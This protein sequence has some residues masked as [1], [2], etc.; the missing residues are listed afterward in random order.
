MG[1]PAY[2]TVEQ[3]SA[4][5]DFKA[6]AFEASRLNRLVLSASRRID[7]M[8]HRHFYPLTETRSYHLGGGGGF[9]LGADLFALTAVT[10]D[11][12][13]ITISTVTLS[14]GTPPYHWISQTGVDIDVTGVWTFSQDTTPA[15]ALAEALDDSETGVD[16][17]DSSLIGVGDLILV[18][19][20][21]MI[22]TAKT[23]VDTTVDVSSGMTTADKSDVSLGVPDGTVFAVN[24]ILLLNAERVLIV[25]IDGNILRVKRAWDGTVLATHTS[26]PVDIFAPRTLTVERNAVGTTAATHSDTTAIT[27]NLAPGPIVDLCIAEAIT[28]YQQESSGYGR[29]IGSGDNVREAR[30]LGL[31]EAREEAKHYKRLRMAAV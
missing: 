26:S 27:R 7:Q 29:T 8:L 4:A 10:A 11:T 25:D 14:P 17:T 20:E 15:G 1:N 13:A 6:S 9:W 12:V 18:D 22:V 28:T 31:K 19:T 3:V 21:Q 23:M 5:L 16:V 2:A 24:E 30:G